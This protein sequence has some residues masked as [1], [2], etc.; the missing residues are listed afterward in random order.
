M[1]EEL[2]SS[3]KTTSQSKSDPSDISSHNPTSPYF[4]HSSD[5]P[6][7][8]LVSSLLN[9][10]NYPTWSRAI[11]NALKAKNKFGFVDV[12]STTAS[13]MQNQPWRFGLTLR[14]DSPKILSTDPLPSLSKAYA[15][16]IREE[17]QQILQSTRSPTM[18]AAAFLVKVG[19]L[20]EVLLKRVEVMEKKFDS[21]TKYQRNL[22]YE[23]GLSNEESKRTSEA[24]ESY[25][26]GV[27]AMKQGDNSLSMPSNCNSTES[28]IGLPSILAYNSL[29][30]RKSKAKV[31]RDDG[32]PDLFDYG[33]QTRSGFNSVGTE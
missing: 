26:I 4:L 12:I 3:N 5:H 6:G 22:N 29:M 17:K 24:E 25:K 10:D 8:I 13:L 2:A 32:L 27:R 16:I 30:A 14:K 23:F 19:P 11:T 9:G 31:D 18:E 20:K 21:M 7:A 28:S 1:A 15:L 33:A